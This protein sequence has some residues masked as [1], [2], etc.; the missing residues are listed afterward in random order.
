MISSH[1]LHIT[2]LILVIL[3]FTVSS[4]IDVETGKNRME[5]VEKSA[6]WPLTRQRIYLPFAY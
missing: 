3:P 1:V 5:N 4:K 2:T 6:N